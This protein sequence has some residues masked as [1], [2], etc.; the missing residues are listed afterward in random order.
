[1]IHE[2]EPSRFSQELDDLRAAYLEALPDKVQRIQRAWSTI[3]V[4]EASEETYKG[5]Y[6]LIHNLAGGAG[7]Y[8]FSGVSAQARAIL[9]KMK[10]LLE[11]ER[12][13]SSE[14]R[15]VVGQ[16]VE[17]LQ[18]SVQNELQQ[19]HEQTSFLR[20]KPIRQ[21]PTDVAR[22]EVFLVEDDPAQAHYL[23]LMLKQAGHQVQAFDKLDD[24]KV[25]LQAFEPTAIIMDMVFPEGEMAGANTIASLQQERKMPIPIFFVSTR[26]DFEARLQAVRAGAWHY[27]TKPV[28][29]NKL[30]D[31]LDAYVCAPQKK[32]KRVL[33]VDDDP[34]IASFFGSHLEMEANLTTFL[35]SDPLHILEKLDEVEPDLILMDYH[36]PECNG[37]ELAAVIRQHET[38]TDTPIIFLTEESNIETQLTA[39][40]IGSD[41]FFPKSMGPDRLVVAVQSRMDRFDQIAKNA[42][43]LSWKVN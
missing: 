22:G 36:M 32:T 33:L 25:A 37:L 39:M 38:Y 7:M 24:V 27:F 20:K 3:D 1:M 43:T 5:F 29:V 34:A 15:M 2:T 30:V 14:Y 17:R 18:Q 4:A 31:L 35:L 10:P 19:S 41:D 6:R 23:S 16:L 8:G 28:D 21:R 40:N 11:E 42:S 9:E 13:L 26:S 12:T